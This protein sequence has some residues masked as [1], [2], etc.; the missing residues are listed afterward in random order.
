MT[1]TS[2]PRSKSPLD[3]L[4]TLWLHGAGL[5]GDTWDEITV[6]HS[7]AIAPDLPGHGITP[8]VPTPRVESYAEALSGIVAPG[9]VLVGHSLGGMIALELAARPG[10]R[11][12]ALILVESVPTVRYGVPSRFAVAIARAVFGTIPTSWL[13]PLAGWGESRK[14]R[15]ELLRQLMRV[16]KVGIMNALEAVASYDGRPRLSEI[17]VPTLVIVGKRNFA[18]HRIAGSVARR[19]K[20]AELIRLPGGHML[21]TDNP[22]QLKRCI[23]AFLQRRVLSAG[24]SVADSDVGAPPHSSQSAP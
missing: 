14:T 21:H 3:R 17:S 22:T 13:V 10:S 2:E 9:S 15:A 12:A 4:D 6:D 18:A 1:Q 7:R 16:N 8:F 20:G 11:I 5:S 23:E 24:V 19:V